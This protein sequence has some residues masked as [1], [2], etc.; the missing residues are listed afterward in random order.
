[1]KTGKTMWV[2]R[3]RDDRCPD[4]KYFQCYYI[5][6]RAISP[7][8]ITAMPHYISVYNHLYKSIDIYI[9]IYSL[10]VADVHVTIS[11]L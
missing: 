6:Q 4:S 8:C 5:L 9:Y 1:M 3:C 7:T 11:L 2:L 10:V